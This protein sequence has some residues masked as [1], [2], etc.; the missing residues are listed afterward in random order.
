MGLIHLYK[1]GHINLPAFN[2][3]VLFCVCMFMLFLR[4]TTNAE[5]LNLREYQQK[6]GLT[7]LLY[8]DILNDGSFS[9][10]ALNKNN[11]SAIILHYTGEGEWKRKGEFSLDK[12]PFTGLNDL[13]PDEINPE[14]SVVVGRFKKRR[15]LFRWTGKTGLKSIGTPYRN[16]DREISVGCIGL[17]HDGS[18]ILGQWWGMWVE[19]EGFRGIGYPR[20]YRSMSPKVLSGD[21][22]TVSEILF[23]EYFK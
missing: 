5:V 21:G 14:G 2:F 4:I 16:K 18:V 11:D 19:N 15:E 3:K 20:W 12:D 13:N 17:S 1:G 10:L 22:R 7:F 6:S 23:A 8:S 9:I